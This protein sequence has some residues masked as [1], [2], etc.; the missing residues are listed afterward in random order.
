MKVINDLLNYKNMK[1][2]QDDEYF[3]FSLD[4]V[5]LPNF[6][7]INKNVRKILDLGTGNA[8]ILLFLSTMTDAE[9]YG[10]ELQKE[11]YDLAEETLEL[12]NLKG[13]IN[14]INDNMK[15]LD[16]YFEINSFD[17]IVSN[18]PYFKLNE[19]SNINQSLQ[20]TIARHEKE[21]T[22]SELV[23][24]AKKYL[25]NNGTFAMVHRV[26]RM[27]EIIE[28]FRKNNIEPKR[29]QLIYP[30]VNTEAN[31]F[32]IEGRKNGQVGLKILPPIIAHENN[33]KYTKEIKK[34]FQ[35]GGKNETDSRIG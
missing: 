1:I 27:I 15:N 31:M 12:N 18:P 24:I 14:L 19:K 33:G 25:K 22:L 30:K 21:I 3:N 23:A 8:P 20:K 10:I 2:V 32:L 4:S 34:V 6:I 28:E 17:I 16:K 35:E 29:I 5:L 7:K 11:I 9:L 13:R 26:D